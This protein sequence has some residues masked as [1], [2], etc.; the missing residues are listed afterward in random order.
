MLRA[1]SKDPGSDT[2]K[3]EG[4]ESNELCWITKANSSG[5]AVLR[6]GREESVFAR[7]SADE[8]APDSAT[9]QMNGRGPDLEWLRAGQAEPR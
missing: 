9:L 8:D 3:A 6:T 7:S 2:S 5:Q 4:V 1:S